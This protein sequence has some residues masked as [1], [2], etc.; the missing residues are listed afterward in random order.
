[1]L[2]APF[3]NVRD[4]GAQPVEFGDSAKVA[5]GFDSTAAFQA[6]LDAAKPG[7]MV[8]VPTGCY[9][10]TAPLRLTA[11]TQLVGGGLGGTVLTSEKPMAGLIHCTGIGGPMTVIRDLFFAGPLGGNWECDALYLEGC[12]G[13]TVRDCWFGGWRRALRIDGGSD[14]WVR[15]IVFELNQEGITARAA[16]LGWAYSN[17]RFFDCYGYHNS[18]SGMTCENLRGLQIL[19]CYSLGTPVALSLKSCVG[20]TIGDAQILRNG[21]ACREGLVLEDCQAVTVR[22]CAFDHMDQSALRATRCR[23]L[24]INANVLTRTLVGDALVLEQCTTTTVTGNSI[25]TAARHGLRATAC[26]HTVL[27][28]NTVDAYGQAEEGRAGAY[29]IVCDGES[30]DCTLADNAVVPTEGAGAPVH[31]APEARRIMVRGAETE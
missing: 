31:V 3:L 13:V 6:A 10:M 14:L 1:M 19:G 12:N 24:T 16:E 20:V 8:F 25:A 17:L 2:T 4:F 9:R 15:N 7:G 11:G 21:D 29:G 5:A 28:Q 23:T 27:A 26:Q 18:R 30:T 22:G